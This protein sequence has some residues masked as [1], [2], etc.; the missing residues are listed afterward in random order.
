MAVI[1]QL[2]LRGTSE[3]YFSNNML[4]IGFANGNLAMIDPDSEKLDGNSF[5]LGEASSEFERII[6]V[7]AKPIVTS[8]LAIGAAY[9]KYF[10][11]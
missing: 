9:Q 5:N 6:D 4:F 7:D 1:P 3:P 8:G 2:T 10:C 11:Y